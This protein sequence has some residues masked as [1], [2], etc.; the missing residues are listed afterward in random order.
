[1]SSK[2]LRSINPMT[3]VVAGCLISMIGCSVR[4]DF[5]LFRHPETRGWSP[6]GLNSSLWR[7]RACSGASAAFRQPSPTSSAPHGY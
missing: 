3:V 5:G 4:G 2:A 6:K 1:M 7:C